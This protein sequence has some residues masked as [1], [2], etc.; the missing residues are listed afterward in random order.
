[1]TIAKRINQVA[2]RKQNT[3]H[4]GMQRNDKNVRELKT[5]HF[6]FKYPTSSNIYYVN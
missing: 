2:C 3:A 5:V 6:Y 4:H 1:M